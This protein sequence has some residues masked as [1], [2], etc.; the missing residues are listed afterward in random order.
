MI[1][2]KSIVFDKGAQRSTADICPACLRKDRRQ[3]VR[4]GGLGRLGTI[5][6]AFDDELGR[7]KERRRSTV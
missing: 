1:R 2:R 3:R 6:S 7:I 4:R 5:H